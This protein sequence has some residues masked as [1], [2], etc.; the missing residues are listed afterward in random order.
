MSVEFS[1]I[2][3]SPYHKF[4]A[5]KIQP[6]NIAWWLRLCIM[7][8]KVIGSNIFLVFYYKDFP[9]NQQTNL[10]F[11]FQIFCKRDFV[12][13]KKK[14]PIFFLRQPF[15]PFFVCKRDQ[16]FQGKNNLYFF[17]CGWK[18]FCHFLKNFLKRCF[19]KRILIVFF[20]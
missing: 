20:Y 11:P 4:L 14:Y 13:P 17:G 15:I 16:F 5:R 8:P 9:I 10:F 12:F 3:L 19:P 1:P 18:T 2:N 6:I 7:N